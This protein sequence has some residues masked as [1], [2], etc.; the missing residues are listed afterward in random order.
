MSS[1]TQHAVSMLG[2]FFAWTTGLGSTAALL[3]GAACLLLLPA[4]AYLLC[5]RWLWRTR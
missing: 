2:F 4:T 3:T 1:I 5:R